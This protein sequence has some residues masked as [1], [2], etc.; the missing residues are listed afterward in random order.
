MTF[1]WE[2]TTLLSLKTQQ[3]KLNIKYKI[4]IC[5]Y[6]FCENMSL[7]HQERSQTVLEH[8]VFHTRNDISHSLVTH[9]CIPILP[10]LQD[11]HWVQ[12]ARFLDGSDAVLLGVVRHHGSGLSR[13][14]RGLGLWGDDRGG[15]GRN[16]RRCRRRSARRLGRYQLLWRVRRSG[17]VHHGA[18]VEERSGLQTDRVKGGAD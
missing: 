1:L 4:S 8:P 10:L 7:F 14:S 12:A 2:E 5:F 17:C 18:F 16:R 13:L 11:L 9:S 15:G 3:R 6:K